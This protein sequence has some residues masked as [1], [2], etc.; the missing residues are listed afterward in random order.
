LAI[1]SFA[2]FCGVLAIRGAPLVAAVGAFVLGT[3]AI[4]GLG[5]LYVA[6]VFALRDTVF[7]PYQS[8]R[9]ESKWRW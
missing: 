1:A 3:I 4:L 9:S 8:V 2:A 7:G 6:I 5:Y